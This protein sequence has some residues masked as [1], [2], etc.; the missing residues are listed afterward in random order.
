MTYD[1]FVKP[2][3]MCFTEGQGYL[4]RTLAPAVSA[5]QED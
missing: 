2:L 5:S 3:Q 4:A 1:A